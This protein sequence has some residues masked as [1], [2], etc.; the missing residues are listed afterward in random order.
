[1]NRIK[2]DE[3]SAA[4]A[5]LID[6]LAQIAKITDAPVVF[7]AQGIKLHAGAPEF[8]SRQQRIG[9]I[10]ALRRND[11]AARPAP[12][13]LRERQLVIA[14]GDPPRQ[15]QRHFR[16]GAALLNR[17]AF[18]RQLPLEFTFPADRQRQTAALDEHFDQRHWRFDVYLLARLPAHRFQQFPLG[19]RSD[20][21]LLTVCVDVSGGDPSFDSRLFELLTLHSRSFSAS[22]ARSAADNRGSS[23]LTEHADTGSIEDSTSR[24]LRLI[25]IQR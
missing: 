10:A 5:H 20:S 24:P 1:M 3:S 25:T 11:N 9:F 14:G 7:R 4:L 15:R 16:A 6:Q 22:P 18:Q 21:L 17:P 2:A 13:L 19:C 12:A 8:F 23:G